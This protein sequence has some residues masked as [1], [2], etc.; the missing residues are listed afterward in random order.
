[1]EREKLEFKGLLGKLAKKKRD[2][3]REIWNLILQAKKA[4][5]SS[6][7]S[8][9]VQLHRHRK[10]AYLSETSE[11]LNLTGIDVKRWFESQ[12]T[13]YSKIFKQ[14]SGQAPRE[15]TSRQ[16]WV[17]EQMVSCSPTSEG[18]MPTE[19]WG[20]T[21]VSPNRCFEQMQNPHLRLSSAD[22]VWL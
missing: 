22:Y 7:F 19:V 2:A 17:Y 4:S 18:K 5:V 8:D 21:Q 10:E 20:S 16:S 14:Q 1:M 12:R 9:T 15:L 6:V 3:K 13:R 11:E